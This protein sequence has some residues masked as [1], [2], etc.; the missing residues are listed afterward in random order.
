MDINVE[1]ERA[2]MGSSKVN[3]LTPCEYGHNLVLISGRVN[4]LAHVNSLMDADQEEEE[5]ML[6][7]S[8]GIES[9]NGNHA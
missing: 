5:R 3:G 2:P 4:C 7:F 1:G 9:V 8:N 6:L